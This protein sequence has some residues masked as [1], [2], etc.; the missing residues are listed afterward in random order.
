MPSTWCFVQLDVFVLVVLVAFPISR[1]GSWPPVATGRAF[2][3]LGVTK[4]T[5]PKVP[6]PTTALHWRFWRRYKLLPWW[7]RKLFRLSLLGSAGNTHNK[8]LSEVTKINGSKIVKWCYEKKWLCSWGIWQYLCS[9]L[10]SHQT[11][12]P[13]NHK[14][15]LML[16]HETFQCLM[17][18]HDLNLVDLELK[19]LQHLS[20][21]GQM[22]YQRSILRLVGG[23]K[24]QLY[25]AH[26][27]EQ[28]T[29]ITG[30]IWNYK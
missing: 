23:C 15:Q 12:F 17:T 13:S 30:V 2:L 21:C 28:S 29:S 19:I 8:C 26:A 9:R 6:R 11:E 5:T 1:G 14:G 18:Q 24:W 7:R 3:S 25:V 20:E 22:K 4:R 16:Y 27:N 10:S